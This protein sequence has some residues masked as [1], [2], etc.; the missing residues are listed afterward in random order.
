M[1]QLCSRHTNTQPTTHKHKGQRMRGGSWKDLPSFLQNQSCIR[2]DSDLDTPWA[3]ILVHG[4][5]QLPSSIPVSLLLPM[6]LLPISCGTLHR[7]GHL[8]KPSQR[9]ISNKAGLGFSTQKI[10]KQNVSMATACLFLS[11]Q[12]PRAHTWHGYAT[13]Q[14]QN[15]AVGTDK[16]YSSEKEWQIVSMGRILEWLT[17]H[18]IK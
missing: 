11:P 3:Y 18:L 2:G 6:T 8:L 17:G 7:N 13:T 14:F 15:K 10:Q 1:P 4:P 16:T 9:R 12:R 5:A